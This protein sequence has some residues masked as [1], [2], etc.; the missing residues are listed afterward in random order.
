[1]HF[2]KPSFCKTHKNGYIRRGDAKA[3]D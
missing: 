2:P 1:V 3:R